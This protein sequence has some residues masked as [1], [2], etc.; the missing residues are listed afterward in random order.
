M[1]T[2]T[3]KVDYTRKVGGVGSI[4]V[5]ANSETMAI[6]NARNLCATGSD[7]RNAMETEDVYTKPRK[8]G[9][10]GFN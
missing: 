10:A 3:Y 5:K 4:L 8:Q 1:T 2:K 7:F 6:V 9:F